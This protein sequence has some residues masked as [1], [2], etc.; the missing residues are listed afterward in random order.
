MICP[1]C[2]GEVSKRWQP[3]QASTIPS[4]AAVLWACGAC[5]TWGHRLTPAEARGPFRNP[6]TVKETRAPSPAN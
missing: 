4:L 2:S 1:R 5:G 3:K 6:K